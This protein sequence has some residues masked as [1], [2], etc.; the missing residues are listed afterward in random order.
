MLTIVIVHNRQVSLRICRYRL[1]GIAFTNICRS[2]PLTTSIVV[3]RRLRN[4][5]PGVDARA[6]A[7]VDARVDAGVGD[8]AEARANA[9]VDTEADTGSD[10][11]ADAGV[12]AKA[13][14]G[15][16]NRAEASSI[17]DV[18]S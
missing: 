7:G 16:G 10:A 5:A 1:Y 2:T 18:I 3:G 17:A 13:D 11:E 4:T 15:A 6:D 14:A 9:G 12:D 8:R